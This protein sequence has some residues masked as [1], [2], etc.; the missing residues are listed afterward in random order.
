MFVCVC[1]CVCVCACVCVRGMQADIL[2]HRQEQIRAEEAKLR[3]LTQQIEKLDIELSRVRE[4][5]SSS[6]GST[7]WWAALCM[8]LDT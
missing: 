3:N 4:E 8:R 7:S 2:D 6:A 1:V 5:V